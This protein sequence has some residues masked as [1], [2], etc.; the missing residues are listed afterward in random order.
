MLFTSFSF[1]CAYFF[2]VWF[3]L[4][5]VIGSVVCFGCFGWLDN[6][7]GL[8]VVLCLRLFTFRLCFSWWVVGST[9]WWVLRLCVWAFWVV[10]LVCGL[11]VFCFV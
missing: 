10:A 4:N 11:C 3:D 7:L 5:V 9:L 6:L 1:A 2:S 8:V